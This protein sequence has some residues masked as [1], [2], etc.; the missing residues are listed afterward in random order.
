MRQSLASN[1][2]NHLWRGNDGQ[3]ESGVEMRGMEGAHG[4]VGEGNKTG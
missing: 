3:N 1:G 4:E 2:W